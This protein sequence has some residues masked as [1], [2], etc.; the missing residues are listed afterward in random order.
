[1]NTSISEIKTVTAAFV[2]IGNEIL[3][4]RTKDVNL[5]YL[6]TALVQVGIRLDEVRV[7]R[8]DQSTI[9]NTVKTLRSEY[10]YVFTSGGIGP[11]HDDIT[12]DSIALSFE[13]DVHHHPE[14]LKRMKAH[15]KKRGV[16]LN[17]ARLRMA[18]TPLGASLINN[19]I[20]AA[21]G[22]TIENVHVMAGVPSVFQA[23]VNELLPTLR[24][25]T[26]IYSRTVISNLGEGTVANGLEKIQSKYPTIDIGSYPFFKN[27]IY[28]TSLV[29]RGAQVN[30]LD[31]AAKDIFNLIKEYGGHPTDGDEN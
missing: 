14:A 17:E 19:P 13:L 2:I 18:R 28:G 23:M 15:A 21:P 27:G 4:G 6:A 31:V 11:T 10:D 26:K 25:G 9:A 22:F 20:S 3:S 12:C 5:S 8:D 29:L 30:D 24:R 7:I 16:E 1:M